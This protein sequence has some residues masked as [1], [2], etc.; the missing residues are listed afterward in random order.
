MYIKRDIE[1]KIEK[2]LFEKE[3][4]AV[5][6]PRQ[7]GKTTLIEHIL[8]KQ[9]G[10]INKISFD[11]QKIMSLFEEDPDSFIEKHVKN[12]DFIFIDEI[13]YSKKSGKILKYIY[14]TTKQKFIIS[15]SSASE[16]SISSLKYLVG[17]IVIFNLLPFSF[18]EF[19]R[20]KDETLLSIYKKQKFLSSINSEINQHIEEFILYGGYPRVVLTNDVD[21]KKIFLQNIFDTYLLKE[22]KEIL[23]LSNQRELIN[24]LKA[25]SLQIGNLI[26]Y[27]HLSISSGFNYENIKKYLSI[28]EKT[29]VCSFINSFH[30][31]KNTELIKSSKVYFFDLG[32]RNIIIDNFSKERSDKGFLF[33]NFL[34][35]EFLKNDLKPKFW[36]TK[37]K[38]EVD[39]II[40]KENQIIPIEVKSIIK[41]DDVSRSFNSFIDKYKPNKGFIVSLEYESKTKRNNTEII[42][43]PFSKIISNLKN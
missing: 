29:Y 10:K 35:T 11:N 34:F 42:F 32:F 2:F 40:E 9:K 1:N 14:D 19:L 21:K 41:N 39:F 5:I 12:Y 27:D 17:R 24:L 31:N 6:G 16:L 3:I 36:R 33:E 7:C 30:T 4:L 22:I 8:N 43:V 13:Q 18:E 26:N 37:A 23:G 20:S 25:L 28:L 38:A 15:G